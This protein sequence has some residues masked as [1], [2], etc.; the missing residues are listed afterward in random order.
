M[1][2]DYAGLK[3]ARRTAQLVVGG[4]G[5]VLDNSLNL[6]LCKKES[7][8]HHKAQE[9][10]KAIERGE[11]PTTANRDGAISSP[12]TIHANPYFANDAYWGMMDTSKLGL[13]MG[14]QVKQGMPLALDPQFI[15]YDTKE[16]KYS[17]QED[18]EFGF[19]D[20]RNMVLSDGTNA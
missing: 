18:Y 9:L 1:D 14:Y 11:N 13:K 2:F 20:V 15:D 6:L 19:N 7:T 16:I 4:V 3:A 8:V 10:L 17:T 12:Y 5:E